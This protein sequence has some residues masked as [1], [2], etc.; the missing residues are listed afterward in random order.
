V[1]VLIVTATEAEAAPVRERI[2]QDLPD[3]SVAFLT[4]GIGMVATAYSLTRHLSG[5][6]YD[7]VLGIG[8]AG[9]IDTQLKLG[10]V[11][12]VEEEQLYELGAQDGDDFLSPAD[13]GLDAVSRFR[14]LHYARQ[15]IPSDVLSVKGITVNTVHGNDNSIA[16]LRSRSDASVES[17]EGAAFYCVCNGF[18]VPCLELRAISNHVERRNRSA[19]DIPLALDRLASVVVQYLKAVLGHA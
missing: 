15:Y 19:W 4:A 8:I 10:T 5:H 1:N 6:S 3:A 7:L 2:R 9:A 14:P 12:S 11:V 18:Q 13:M 16:V 17:M